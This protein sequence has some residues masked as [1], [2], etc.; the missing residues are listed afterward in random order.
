MLVTIKDIARE[1]GVSP[2]AVS[3][4]LNNRAGISLPLKRKIEKIAQ[5]L[6]YTP[7]IKARQPMFEMGK[8]GARLL[9]EAIEKKDFS[10]KVIRLKSQIILRQSTHKEAQKEKLL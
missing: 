3:K 4:A 8:Q 10:N 6:G 1:A 7:Y 2:A 9:L 5:R